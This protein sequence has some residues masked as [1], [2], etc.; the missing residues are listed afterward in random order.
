[1]TIAKV[2]GG[3]PFLFRITGIIMSKLANLSLILSAAGVVL[4]LTNYFTALRY[5]NL[6]Y[7]GIAIT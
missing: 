1:L 5:Y 3:I 6:G 7:C 4:P 2:D